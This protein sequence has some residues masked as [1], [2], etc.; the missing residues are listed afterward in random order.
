M[1][2]EICS[3]NSCPL[4][5]GM[6][7][8]ISKDYYPSSPVKPAFAIHVK[9]LELYYEMNQLGPSSKEAYGKALTRLYWKYSDFEV[10]T[11]LFSCID[12][13]G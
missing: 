7:G 13:A 4:P 10:A 12:L 6:L 8:F 1:E 5:A 3:D 11:K 2:F 9:V